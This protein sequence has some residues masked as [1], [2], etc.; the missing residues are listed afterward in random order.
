MRRNGV[1]VVTG[2]MLAAAC[3]GSGSGPTGPASPPPPGSI[4]GRVTSN[5]GNRPVAGAQIASGGAVVAVTGADGGFSLP[6]P[7]ALAV[8]ISAQGYLTRQTRISGDHT[9]LVI[10]LIYSLIDPRVRR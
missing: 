3:G 5:P 8:T 6:N 2:L 10:D 4:T 1:W 9:D 7:G